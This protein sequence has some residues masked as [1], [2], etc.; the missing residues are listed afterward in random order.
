MRC[1][2]KAL[3][4]Y[5]VVML[6]TACL[7]TCDRTPAGRKFANWTTKI[8]TQFYCERA[9]PGSSSYQFPAYIYCL[10]WRDNGVSQEF[11]DQAARD[12]ES[13]VQKSDRWILVQS[14][15]KGGFGGSAISLLYPESD[16]WLAARKSQSQGYSEHPVPV[17]FT[18]R[19]RAL[20]DSLDD[21]IV[22]NTESSEDEG[23]LSPPDSPQIFVTIG[24]KGRIWRFSMPRPGSTNPDV[25]ELKVTPTYLR[26]ASVLGQINSI[27][28]FEN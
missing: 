12:L 17:S 14:L 10:H 6:A 22:A 21:A 20:F 24:D 5:L 1:M 19:L 9:S 18:P 3:Q 11:F 2:G 16:R 26:R 25:S 7:A 13:H 15:S 8:E 28:E 23:V 4:G 27:M